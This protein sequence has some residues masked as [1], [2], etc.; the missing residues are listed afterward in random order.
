[1]KKL[2][3]YEGEDAI[4]LWADLIESITIIFQDEDVKAA[5]KAK[6]AKFTIASIMLR[7]HKKECS[8]ILLRIDP[9]PLNG[10]N[11]VVRLVE[12]I[13][14][15]GNDSTLQSFFGF[16]AQEKDGTAFGSVTEN[17]EEKEN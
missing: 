9:T 15:V 7:K 1:M 16:G 10:L 17:T 12:V 14:E 6:K 11:I 2:A 5:I 8:D 4:L 3:D 13:K